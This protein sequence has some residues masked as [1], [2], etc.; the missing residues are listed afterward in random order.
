MRKLIA[1]WLLLAANLFAG[2]VTGLFQ[3][4]TGGVI[5]NGTLTFNLSQPAVLPGT[6]SSQSGV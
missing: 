3:T 6:N 4:P 5:K 2:T 1:L